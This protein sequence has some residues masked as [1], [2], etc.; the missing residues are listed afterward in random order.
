MNTKPIVIA[1]RERCPAFNGRVGGAAEFGRLAETAS[2]DTPCAFV[3][4]LGETPEEP[5]GTSGYRQIVHSNFAVMCV[6]DARADER[7]QEGN[8]S[9][10]EVRAELFR[11]L[12]MW[13]PFGKASS[14]IDFDG[15]QLIELDR[16]RIFYQF[17]FVFDYQ[18]T[19]AD[20]YQPIY[21]ANLG[22]LETVDLDVHG[23][24]MEPE[25]ETIA[26]AIFNLKQNQ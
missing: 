18:I 24:D 6:L 17:E 22:N 19:T 4:P 12:L 25:S 15:S 1:L 26:R 23:T 3:I 11:A 13:S 7:G 16:S 8:D 20:T 14:E 2:F 9:L 10:D 21:V 5:L